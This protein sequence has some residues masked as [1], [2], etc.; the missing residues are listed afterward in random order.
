MCDEKSKQKGASKMV[1]QATHC[2][3]TVMSGNMYGYHPVRKCNVTKDVDP[4][5]SPKGE[6]QRHRRQRRKIFLQVNPNSTPDLNK[7][8]TF[9]P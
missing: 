5:M 7:V 8:H 9:T 6:G 1:V 4:M 3:K 2:V